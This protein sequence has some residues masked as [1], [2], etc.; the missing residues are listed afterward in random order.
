MGKAAW[1]LLVWLFLRP[2]IIILDEA[3][4]YVGPRRAFRVDSDEVKK[5]KDRHGMTVISITHDLDEVA[6][7]DRGLSERGQVSTSTPSELSHLSGFRI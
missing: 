2:D 3:N 4:Q 7:S 1:L 5:I 6:L